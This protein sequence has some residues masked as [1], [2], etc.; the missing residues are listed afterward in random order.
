MASSTAERVG[1]H[2]QR[3]RQEGLRPVELWVYDTRHPAVREQLRRDAEIM[4][5]RL[6]SPEERAVLAEVGETFDELMETL[7]VAEKQ[8][9]G[10]G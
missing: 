9:A 1:R 2:R 6:G 3:L 5:A 10:A 7:E 8:R 4:R